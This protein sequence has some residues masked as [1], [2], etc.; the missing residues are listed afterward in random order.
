VFQD[1]AVLDELVRRIV[2]VA[3]PPRI[4]LFGSAARG[5]MRPDSD[6]D[7]LVVV[8]DG[9]HTRRTAGDLHE[10]AARAGIPMDLV[11]TTESH[12]SA[13]R[14]N[15]WLVFFHALKEGREPT[16]SADGW[17]GQAPDF[18]GLSSVR[19]S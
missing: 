2:E 6:L 9:T 17:T 13:A 15:E 16:A 11:V 8:P 10:R 5:D 7:V 18:A 1:Q 12:L 3:K 19:Q 14:N 4:I